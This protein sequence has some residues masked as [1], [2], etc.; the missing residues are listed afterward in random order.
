MLLDGINHV[1]VLTADTDRLVA[2]YSSMFDATVDGQMQDGE[3][4]RLTLVKVGPHSELNVFEIRGND[5]PS[6]QKP[7]FGRGRL[8]HLG[9]QAASIEAFDTIRDRLMAAGAT[10]GFVTD[11][12]PVLS[13]FFVDPDG[14]EGEVCVTNPDAQPGV[15]HPPGTPAARYHAA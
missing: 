11:F 13:L 7:M 10:D 3:E 1:A 8:D 4:T 12:G 2:F 6:R 15:M 14:L 9:L 5:E